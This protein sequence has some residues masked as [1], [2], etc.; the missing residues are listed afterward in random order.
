MAEEMSEKPDILPIRVDDLD[1]FQVLLASET[2]RR[3]HA[4]VELYQ[5]RLERSKAELERASSQERDL[6]QDLWKRYRLGP[7]DQ[8]DQTTG[9]ITRAAVPKK[10]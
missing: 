10:P 6:L 7:D 9:L 8:I 1:R 5:M 4:E 2:V 3:A